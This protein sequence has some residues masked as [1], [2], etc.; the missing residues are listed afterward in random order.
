MRE[1]FVLDRER[2]ILFINL[3]GLRIES[4]EQVDEMSRHVREAYET[5]GRRIYA[6]VNYEGTE[7][8]PEVIDSYGERIKA[9]Y[10][11]FG[12]ATMRYSSSGLTRSVLRYLGAAKDLESNIFA[13]REEAIRAI[14]EI[15]RRS[16]DE[17]D[18]SRFGAFDPR[19]SVLG[20]L[21]IGWMA[22]LML[23]IAF[24]AVSPANRTTAAFAMVVLIITA[25]FTAAM[26]LT[27]VLKPLR[28]MEGF[29]RRLAVS[30][31][32]E[33]IPESG[34]DEIGQLARAL[35]E[36]AMHLRRDIERLSGLYHIS[37][38]MGTGTEVAKINELLTRKV[39]RLLDAEMCLILL[40][41]ER[42][43][44][45]SAQLPGY[46]VS[47]EHLKLLRTRLADR[48]IAT[49]V[50]ATC[51]PYL[52]N[53]A[54]GDPVIS[55]EAAALLG[56]REML[57]VPL[58][59]GERKLGTLEVMNKA[60]G[61]LEEDKQLVTI[62]AAQAAQLL[63]NAQL[64]Q[65]V[66]ATERLAAVGE[67]VAGVA[68]EVRNPL[69]GITTTLSALERRL[70]D[71]ESARPFIE[72][73]KTEAGRLNHLMEQ[74]LEHARPIRPDAELTG[75]RDVIAEAMA[76]FREP[77]KSKEVS[78]ACECA[79]TLPKL[80]LDRRKVH[81]VFVNLLDNAIQHTDPK[82]QV[83]VIV[84]PPENDSSDRLQIEVSD[85]GCGIAPENIGKIFDPFFTTR[86]E[87]TGLG[88]AIAR[89]TIHDHGGAIEV[90]SKPGEG[91]SFIIG[92]PL[93]RYGEKDSQHKG[94]KGQRN[95]GLT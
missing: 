87:G 81:G 91:T 30:G 38:M 92:L 6:I 54:A 18:E 55:R 90:Q 14:Q 71:R 41:D 42:D 22:A 58:Q 35:N 24:Y 27:D 7:I 23:L 46:G 26:L 25:C 29:A 9:L 78:L 93:D 13:T 5:Q 37:L 2:N 49:R 82:G 12:L 53:D 17:R 34:K 95:K 50:F 60:G 48:S 28:Q 88:L 33:A 79:G 44:T 11:H 47:D 69:C 89:K 52:T 59:A 68:H 77:A 4:G 21:S 66:I 45:I 76:E 67:L 32:F 31:P 94:A 8:A 36:T 10:E 80:R 56:V 3:A 72:V 61:F 39:A 57:A 83:R 75:L 20:K 84:S 62:F 73:V 86:A 63:A 15:E 16:R 65:Q 51:E 40:Y 43:K 70:E 85:T 1:R 19:R 64:F 74:L